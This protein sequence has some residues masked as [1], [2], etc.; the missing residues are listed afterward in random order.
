MKT[1]PSQDPIFQSDREKLA[2]GPHDFIVF[3]GGLKI[4]NITMDMH[5]EVELPRNYTIS[6]MKITG[7]PTPAKSPSPSGEEKCKCFCHISDENKQYFENAPSPCVHCSAPTSPVEEGWEKEFDERFK[8]IQKDCDGNGSIPYPVDDGVW[9]AD[10]C[11]FHAEYIFPLK[12]FIRST[13][14][15]ARKEER[16]SI[17]E[18]LIKMVH[19]NGRDIEI[20]MNDVLRYA[21]HLITNQEI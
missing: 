2:L 16:K 10:Q 13:I 3:S 5:I 8:C 7:V 20:A 19:D 12:S 14:D 4:E 9:E 17:G 21:D 6:P 18:N 15:K 11:Q 1:P